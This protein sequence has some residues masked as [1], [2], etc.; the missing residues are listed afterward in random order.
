M[1]NSNKQI[2][3]LIIKIILKKT[4]ANKTDIMIADRMTIMIIDKIG[5]N[6]LID[7][8]MKTIDSK[9]IG[10]IDHNKMMIII[11]MTID[12]IIKDLHN[13]QIV[14]N[15]ILKVIMQECKI[16]IRIYLQINNNNNLLNHRFKI[17]I[18]L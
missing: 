12:F 2:L 8:S 18:L 14:H 1:T 13:N 15:F 3:I 6:I 10:I 9:I 7:N 16:L 11:M 4:G 5:D 17:I